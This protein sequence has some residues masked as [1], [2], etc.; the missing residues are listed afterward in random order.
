MLLLLISGM[1]IALA[2]AGSGIAV[3]L[4]MLGATG[5]FATL[6]L[7]VWQTLDSFV[8]TAIPLFI[9]MGTVLI[10][11]GL[12]GELMELFS[13]WFSRAPGGLGIASVYSCAVFGAM[14]GSSTAACATIGGMA[15]PEM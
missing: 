15:I 1:P 12:A 7:V 11:S 10:Y 3:V 14:S 9:F 4:L 8:L 13:K 6:G 5:G 2:L